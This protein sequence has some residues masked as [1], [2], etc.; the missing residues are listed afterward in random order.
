MKKNTT[1]FHFHLKSRKV[2]LIESENDMIHSQVVRNGEM[3]VKRNK[4]AVVSEV[5]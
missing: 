5:L 2:K 1:S 4:H 3:L